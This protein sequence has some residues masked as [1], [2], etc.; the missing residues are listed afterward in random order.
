MALFREVEFLEEA[1]RLA[2]P[3]GSA[4]VMNYYPSVRE[5]ALFT[6]LV[7]IPAGQIKFRKDEFPASVGFCVHY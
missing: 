3:A 2:G 6:Y 4:V 5:R 1:G 7:I